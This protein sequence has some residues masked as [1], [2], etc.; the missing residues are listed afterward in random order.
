[1]DMIES[2]IVETT[3]GISNQKLFYRMFEIVYF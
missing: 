1:M 3:N 2:G